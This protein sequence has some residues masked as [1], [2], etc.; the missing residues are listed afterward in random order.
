MSVRVRFA[1]SP[2]GHI[3]VGNVRTALFNYLFARNQEG[4]FILRIEDTDLERSSLES[5]NLIYE[6]LKWLGLDFDEGPEIGGEYAPYRQ[7]ERFDIYN[8]CASELMEKGYAY[9]CFCSKEELDAEREKA[10]AEGRPFIY[11]GK[12]SHLTAEEIAKR[13]A[14]GEKPAIRFRAFKPSIVVKDMIHGEINFPTNAFGDFIIIRPDGTPIYNYVVVVDDA[15]MKITHVIRGDDHLSNTPKQALIYEALGYETPMFAHIPMILGPDHSKLSK[16]HGNTSVEQFRASGY[17]PEAMINYMALLSWSSTDE[18]EI[19]SKEELIEKFSLSRVSKS[20][21]VFDFGKLDW[22]N[23]YYIRQKSADELFNLCYPFIVKSGISDGGSLVA[24]KETV[25]AMIMSV[26]DNFTTLADS[27]EYLRVYFE[28][29]SDYT[30][31][32]REI[33]ALDTTYSVM[34]AFVSKISEF[35]QFIE[36]DEYRRIMKE[37]QIE[38]G[39]KGKPLYMA[40]RVGIT[41]STK[42]PELDSLVS[43]LPVRELAARVNDAMAAI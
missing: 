39:T 40:V 8:K 14:A 6:D 21:A 27:P 38:T 7:T 31:E 25:K 33:M 32:A 24:Q 13:E 10:Q 37:I 22:M 1:P 35:Q 34:E 16:R 15:L 30:P 41:G 19:F 11:S 23:G 9:K 42:G 28:R 17:L 4:K 43:L 36:V 29:P 18:Q 20:A 26:K 12:C 3:H 2:T 5:E